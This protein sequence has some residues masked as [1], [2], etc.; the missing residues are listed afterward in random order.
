MVTPSMPP[1]AAVD[2]PAAWRVDWLLG[3]HL[4]TPTP[5]SAAGE[6][7][8]PPATGG[9]SR[10]DDRLRGGIPAAGRDG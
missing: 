7:L 3:R 8:H 10:I 9:E 4:G 6:L 5:Q 2:G 1:A